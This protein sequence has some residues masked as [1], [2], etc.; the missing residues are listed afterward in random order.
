M[1]TLNDD[2]ENYLK[3][4]DEKYGTEYCPTGGLGK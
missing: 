1:K 4:I 2:F 3:S